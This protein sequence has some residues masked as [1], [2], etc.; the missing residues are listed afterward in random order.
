MSLVSQV[1]LEQRNAGRIVNDKRHSLYVAVEYDIKHCPRARKLMLYFE[2]TE[3]PGPFRASYRVS[4]M[5]PDTRDR[6]I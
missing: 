6:E 4:S 5:G 2:L 3:D 1:N